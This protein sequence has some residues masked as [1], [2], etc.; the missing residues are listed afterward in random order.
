MGDT[1]DALGY[2]ADVKSRAKE[3]VAGKVDSVKEHLG[4]AGQKSGA[5]RDFVEERSPVCLYVARDSTSLC[6]QAVHVRQIRQGRP[7]SDVAPCKERDR[8]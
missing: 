4:L 8:R 7:Q 6:R 3:N 5:L 1:I 2:K